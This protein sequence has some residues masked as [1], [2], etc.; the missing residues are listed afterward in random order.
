MEQRKEN[1]KTQYIPIFLIWFYT[2]LF[3]LTGS[4]AY[5]DTYNTFIVFIDTFLLSLSILYYFSDGRKW[6]FMAKKSLLTVISLNVLTE[7]SFIVD[8]PNYFWYYST[9]ICIYFVSLAVGAYNYFN[10]KS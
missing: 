3:F 2:I 6:G 9:I 7:M 1:S 8:M 10:H 4:E 5:A